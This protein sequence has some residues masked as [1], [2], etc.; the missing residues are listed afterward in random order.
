M[1]KLFFLLFIVPSLAFPSDWRPLKKQGREIL[2]LIKEANLC[3]P[4]KENNKTTFCTGFTLNETDVSFLGNLSRT[5]C[6]LEI[7][8]LG[9]NVFFNKKPKTVSEKDYKLFR[10]STQ[11]AQ[12]YYPAKAVVF[13]NSA[14]RI[15]CVHELLHLYQR[16]KESKS[17]LNPLARLKLENSFLK[18]I[19]IKIEEVA[20]F[21][22]K[23][24]IEQA[25]K[26][27]K[28]L[29]PFLQILGEWRK[30]ITWLDE[31]EIYYFILN[32]CK[33]LNCSK[34]DRD[35][36]IS[37]L[38][39]FKKHLPQVERG[40]VLSKARKLLAKKQ[41]ESYKRFKKNYSYPKEKILYKWIKDF[42]YSEKSKNALVGNENV[43]RVNC[44]N[45][46]LKF[47]GKNTGF[48]QWYR[49]FI[50]KLHKKNIVKCKNYSS[51]GFWENAYKKGKL[52]RAKFEEVVLDSKWIAFEN[53]IKAFE[54]YL[55]QKSK[56]SKREKDDLYIRYLFEFSKIPLNKIP[57]KRKITNYQNL[58]F[59]VFDHLPYIKVGK[60]YFVLDL[61][62]VENIAPIKWINI[63]SELGLV[64]LGGKTLGF[65]SGLF[66]KSPFIY[67]SK[68]MVIGGSKAK[69][70]TWSI[71][72]LPGK[73]KGLL[74]MSYFSHFKTLSIDLKNF[75]ITPNSKVSKSSRAF[76]LVKNSKNKLDALEFFCDS[77]T[78]IRIDTGSQVFGDISKLRLESKTFSKLSQNKKYNCGG[79]EL[80]G[81]YSSHLENAV[82]FSNGVAINLGFPF[83][84]KFKKININLKDGW[85]EFL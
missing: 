32:N 55:S 12:V 43:A 11:V 18:K 61:G 22:K 64:E 26:A 21:E 30:L 60:D 58:K 41:T 17:K 59:Q 15:D 23:G 4:Q 62:A 67:N 3:L 19:E 8:R 49:S 10:N 80:Q 52:T 38:V 14:G 7:K 78:K 20:A 34:K 37:N 48:N 9:Y 68:T 56:A 79:L 65:S 69:N 16:F 50:L 70:I 84:E 74:G 28:N 45:G 71:S 25:K 54:L 35:I 13:K 44:D 39:T 76:K 40:I 42:K 27:G 81:K 53:K 82:M 6:E 1:V 72:H 57:P 77:K 83:L 73:L 24:R 85:I 66:K 46:R 63:R 75:K 5:S 29:G 2:E 31:K 51:L 33:K 36:A 47:F